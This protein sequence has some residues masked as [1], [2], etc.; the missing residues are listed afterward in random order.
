MFS[1]AKKHA[2]ER[3][4]SANVRTDPFPHIF[5]EEVFPKDFYAEIQ[6]NRLP[7]ES[8][9]PLVS[10]GRVGSQYSPERFCYMPSQQSA[11]TDAA[12]SRFWQELFSTFND[13]DFFNAWMER[14]ASY[15][16]KRIADG[17]G[18]A[19]GGARPQTEIFLMRDKRNYLLR[20]HTDTPAKA[21]SALFY[22]PPND[23]LEFLGTSLYRPKEGAATP[24]GRHLNRDLFDAVGTIPF[25]AN[26]V[27]GFPNLPGSFH[28]V[29]PMDSPDQ[30]RDILLYDI[31]FRPAQTQA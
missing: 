21:V 3:I 28:G 14:F 7:D 9:C 26:S 27:L 29:E 25:R 23:R 6:R 31:K 16:Q 30:V 18:F 11:V 22:L 10:T 17:F 8:Y 1:A 4:R 13:A 5:V 15:L 2:I 20:P 24:F 19:V 12:S